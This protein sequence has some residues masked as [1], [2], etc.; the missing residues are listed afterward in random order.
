MLLPV[1]P[2]ILGIIIVGKEES[3]RDEKKK[4]ASLCDLRQD[5][6]FFCSLMLNLV[7]HFHF[8]QMIKFLFKRFHEK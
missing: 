7:I 8:K 1:T 2:S 5:V 6:N 3:K 4:N